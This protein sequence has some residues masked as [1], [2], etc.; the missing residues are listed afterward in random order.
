MKK[1]L[2]TGSNGFIGTNLV[3]ILRDQNWD[4]S[5]CLV[6]VA[7]P[8]IP[9]QSNEEWANVDIMDQAA[10]MA[11]FD[12][13]KP[14]VV[15]HLAAQT[16]TFP[17]L[18]LQD[19]IVNTKGAEIIFDACQA[20]GVEFVV[21]TSTQFVHQTDTQPV[22]D[23]DYAPHTVYGQSKVIS[24]NTLR[25]SKYTFNWSIIRPT[26]VWGKWHLRYPYE[27]WKV[28]RDGKYFHPNNKSVVRSYAYV[29]NVC[30]Q[31][32]EIIKRQH[33][34][35]ISRQVFYVGDRPI[36]LYDWANA[37]SLSIKKRK[38]TLIPLFLLY[39]VAV[40]G[41]L[42]QKFKIKF[43]ITISRYKSMTSDNPAPMEKTM[44]VLGE[45]HYTLQQGVDITTEW[46]LKFWKDKN[47]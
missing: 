30:L 1:I 10:V 37:F 7:E 19:Y 3:E 6:D 5:A 17:H 40:F 47:I 21:H 44:K 33:E 24:E 29:G 45:S 15:V 16:N 8:K 22:S 28:V 46:L 41:T 34:P 26:N 35:A 39:S 42:L 25:G 31:I 27:F 14:T 13:F 11:C 12:K 20:N 43:P 4:Y 38:V 9:L 18:V 23:T 36:N 2:I 32:V